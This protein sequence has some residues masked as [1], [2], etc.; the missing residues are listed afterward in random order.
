[1]KVATML[2]ILSCIMIIGCQPPEGMGGV[3][4][5]QVDSLKAEIQTMKTDHVTLQTALDDMTKMYNEHMEKFHKG[6]KTI[7]TPPPIQK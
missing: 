3:T 2:I 1:M 6:G 5:A 7:K 4:T